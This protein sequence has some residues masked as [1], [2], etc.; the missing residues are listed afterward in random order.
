MSLGWVAGLGLLAAACA[1]RTEPAPVTGWNPPPPPAV[2]AA[3]VTVERGDTISK[4]ARR[5]GVT[6]WQI[7]Q[8]NHLVAPYRLEVGQALVLPGREGRVQVA[9]MPAPRTERWREPPE[10]AERDDVRQPVA[11]S[12]PPVS[13]PSRI[14]SPEV[15]PSDHRTVPK[16]ADAT[17][18][19][20]T[21]PAAV[22]PAAIATA[23]PPPRAA[24]KRD[25]P[26]PS[27]IGA[28]G[29]I[30]PVRGHVL[31]GF[32]AGHGGTQND[33]IN[34]AARAGAP[35]YA[36]ASG[37]VVYVGNELRGYGNLVLLKHEGGYITAY[38]HNAA[39]LVR[40]GEHVVR[41]QTIAR[42]GKT[43]EVGSPQLHFEIRQGRNPVD[44]VQFLPPE[45]QASLGE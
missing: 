35:V 9:A 32:G 8:A 36:A 1:P 25:E 38:A 6:S 42:V 30:W 28:R 21:P 13:D 43:G 34:I 3:T 23:A 24:M 31:E 41:G 18:P 20:R 12:L 10:R 37:E 14:D 26:A 45:Q 2:Q 5:N 44:P 16:F 27:Q 29:F 19:T 15:P 11:T 7:I 17:P 4:I 22:R 33:G 40:K 39:I